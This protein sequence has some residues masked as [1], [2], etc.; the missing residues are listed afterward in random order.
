M[1]TT[2]ISK[3][4]FSKHLWFGRHFW[5][6]NFSK[7]ARGCASVWKHTKFARTTKKTFNACLHSRRTGFCSFTRLRVVYFRNNGGC[8]AFQEDLQRCVASGRCNARGISIRHVR[9]PGRW[10]PERG[11]ILEHQISSSLRWC[12]VTGAALRMTWHHFLVNVQCLFPKLA[13]LQA[14]RSID[15]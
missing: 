3:S 6:L 15:R 12:C 2:H 9:R 13:S 8:G 4:K 11:Q 1:R 10:F 7:S 14:D 5:K